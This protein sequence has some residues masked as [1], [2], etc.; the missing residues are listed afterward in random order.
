MTFE[1]ARLEAAPC[2]A[3]KDFRHGLAEKLS[4]ILLQSSKTAS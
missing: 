3:S 1:R 4:F 2:A